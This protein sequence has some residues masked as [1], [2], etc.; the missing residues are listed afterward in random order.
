MFCLHMQHLA[1]EAN[2]YACVVPANQQQTTYTDAIYCTHTHTDRHNNTT[3]LLYCVVIQLS[4]IAL[5]TYL[6][7]LRI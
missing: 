6:P 1:Y 4:Q 7:A 5:P 3:L 2:G